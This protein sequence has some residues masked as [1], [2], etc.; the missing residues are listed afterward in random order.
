M[1]NDVFD[2][3]VVNVA[4]T[5]HAKCRLPALWTW[6]PCVTER[7]G[8]RMSTRQVARKIHRSKR[9]SG[10][11]SW[12]TAAWN[13]SQDSR[14][15]TSLIRWTCSHEVLGQCIHV[16]CAFGSLRYPAREC[17]EEKHHENQKEFNGTLRCGMSRHTDN[18][19]FV[20]LGP[21]SF[22]FEGVLVDAHH[23]H[24]FS[25]CHR[26]LVESG[27]R[28]HLLAVSHDHLARVSDGGLSSVQSKQQESR[29]P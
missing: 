3:H 22:F 2:T 28:L 18:H 21:T 4:T 6:C 11:A 20:L 26:A 24:V 5:I 7:K 14:S 27:V 25:S 15:V 17:W 12:S 10:C 13:W 19:P 29:K 23:P 1:R 9:I 8:W 16:T